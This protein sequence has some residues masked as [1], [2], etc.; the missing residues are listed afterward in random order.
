MRLGIIGAAIFTPRQGTKKIWQLF[1]GFG[2]SKAKSVSDR[3]VSRGYL[4][5]TFN[6]P[7]FNNCPKTSQILLMDPVYFQNSWAAEIWHEQGRT[8]IYLWNTIHYVFTH[9]PFIGCYFKKKGHAIDL[10]FKMIYNF[11]Y[12]IVKISQFS[13][14][15]YGERNI[16]V[17]KFYI[18]VSF[19][20]NVSTT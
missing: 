19:V 3:S 11:F 8:I 6:T 5:K 1:V 2:S 14:L 17:W 12:R 9:Q 15:F 13:I 18:F 4:R 16:E 7:S 20:H 10:Q